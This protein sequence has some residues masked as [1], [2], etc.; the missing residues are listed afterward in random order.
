MKIAVFS[1]RSTIASFFPKQ[2]QRTRRLTRITSSFIMTSTCGQ[3]RFIWPKSRC[4]LRICKRP[5]RSG[6]FGTPQSRRIRLV[7]LRCA[8]YNNVDLIAAEDLGIAVV[9]V[10][11]YSPEAVAEHTVALILTLNRKIY[12]SYRQVREGNFSLE[13]LVGFQSNTAKRLA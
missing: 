6:G 3:R 4:D 9:R 2:P 11:A 1:T 13:G 8:G 10:P 5:A 7:A 12:R